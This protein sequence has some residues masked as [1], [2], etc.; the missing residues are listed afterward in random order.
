MANLPIITPGLA[1]PDS[2]FI[3]DIGD[4]WAKGSG[5][6]ANQVI[7][8]G[9]QL[10]TNTM[11]T[12][13]KVLRVILAGLAGGA[14]DG[15]LSSPTPLNIMAGEGSGL[16][17][18]WIGC[19]VKTDTIGGNNVNHLVLTELRQFDSAG[20]STGT[21]T[22][23]FNK[24]QNLTK[25][26]SNYTVYYKVF[27]ETIN[28]TTVEMRLRVY[29]LDQTTPA[30]GIGVT[31]PWVGAGQVMDV[32]TPGLSSSW[33]T[34]EVSTSSNTIRRQVSARGRMNPHIFV[35]DQGAHAQ[36]VNVT[37]PLLTEADKA[38]ILHAWMWN[39]GTPTAGVSQKAGTVLNRGTSQPV[40]VALDRENIKKAF[41]AD[42]AAQPVFT[43]STPG[44]LPDSDTR[45]STSL[46]FIERL[47]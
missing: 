35:Q 24:P 34:A 1:I 7:Q 26:V 19:I 41:Y 15:L 39:A 46:T 30:G 4:A 17:N 18:I 42:F 5:I 6:P 21:T 32:N 33:Y 14:N 23:V 8:H 31:I 9:D 37:F 45:W 43:N 44:W 3:W 38:K 27:A 22:F 20:G 40:I 11:P 36:T 12:T 16:V 10:L 25:T 47:F 2:N 29:F 13:G 28:A